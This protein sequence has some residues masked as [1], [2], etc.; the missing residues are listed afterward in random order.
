MAVEVL[1]TKSFT[2]PSDLPL[3]SALEECDQVEVRLERRRFLPFLAGSARTTWRFRV[4]THG[5]LRMPK[6][7]VV[8]SGELAFHDI[9]RG[10]AAKVG[11]LVATIAPWASRTVSCVTVVCGWS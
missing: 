11:P 2:E 9:E 6:L 7:L 4:V 5:S 10:N 1:T 8:N 3:G